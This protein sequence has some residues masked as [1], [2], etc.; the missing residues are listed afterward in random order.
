MINWLRFETNF[1]QQDELSIYQESTL[2]G[3]DEELYEIFSFINFAIR[4]MSNLGT[5]QATD[6]LASTLVAAPSV[7]STISAGSSFGGLRLVTYPGSPGRKRFVANLEDRGNGAKFGLKMTGFGLLARGFGYYAPMS[8]LGLLAHFARRRC[9]SSGYLQAL[10][11][12]AVLCGHAQLN[13]TIGIGNHPVLAERDPC[14]DLFCSNLREPRALSR[15]RSDR[16]GLDIII[17]R[18]DAEGSQ[19]RPS[20]PGVIDRGAQSSTWMDWQQAYPHLAGVRPGRLSAR[21][22]QIVQEPSVRVPLQLSPDHAVLPFRGHQG[23]LGSP[24]QG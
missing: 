9:H 7:I 22:W 12:A 14:P 8:V 3:T 23:Q 2:S 16:L 19:D 10:A 1:H 21:R 13:R 6:V 24:E 15:W 4:Q 20:Q 11:Q 5:C 17:P 18:W